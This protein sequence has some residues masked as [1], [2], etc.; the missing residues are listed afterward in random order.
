MTQFLVQGGL[1]VPAIKVLRNGQVTLPK[2]MR[3]QLHISEGD[4]L[5][6]ELTDEKILLKPKL[7]VDKKEVWRRLS[8]LMDRVGRRHDSISEEEVEQ[9]ALDAVRA[10]R[11][12]TKKRH[13]YSKIKS[14]A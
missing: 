4:I 6:A 3:Q 11:Q 9:D 2:K 8:A 13:V 5:E 1:D 14:R 12:Q 7:L 10:I